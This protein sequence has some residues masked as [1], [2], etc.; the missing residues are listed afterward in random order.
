VSTSPTPGAGHSLLRR[1]VPV[2]SVLVALS[3]IGV[4]VWMAQARQ[5]VVS[6]VIT[7]PAPELGPRAHRLLPDL[8][9]AVVV[10]PDRPH[11]PAEVRSPER[12]ARITRRRSFVVSTNAAGLRGPPV[13]QPKNSLRVVVLGDSVTFGWGV[14]VE[15]SYPAL[16]G[17]RLGIEVVNTGVPAM[18]PGSMAAWARLHLGG[19]QPDLVLFTRRPDHSMPDPWTDF[20]RAVRQVQNAAGGARVGVV[21]PPVSTFD[22]M[23]AK[24]WEAEQARVRTL[25]A[26]VPVLDLTPAFRQALPLPGVVLEQHGGRQQVVRLPGAAVVVDAAAPAH[27]LADEVIAAFEGDPSLAEPLFFDGG[28][29]DVAGFEVFVNAV[30]AWLLDEK[31][32]P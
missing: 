9:D 31:L 15:A 1:W 19:L 30:Q 12:F 14:P 17:E 10:V 18:K 11:D 32:L 25:V 24:S 26:P 7:R 27:G 29:P 3:S 20:A 4:G 16:L 8:V 21:M 28:H 5:P 6:T 13:R 2:V 23:G 22:T